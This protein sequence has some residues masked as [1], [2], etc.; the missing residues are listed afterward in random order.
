MKYLRKFIK[1][2]NESSSYDD[3]VNNIREQS[4]LLLS[5]LI[6]RGFEITVSGGIYNESINGVDFRIKLYSP[7]RDFT[8]FKW[9]D[10]KDD[11]LPFLNG[12]DYKPEFISF[13]VD[14]RS[15]T[16]PKIHM[17]AKD[18]LSDRVNLEFSEYRNHMNLIDE[19]NINYIYVRF[20]T[21]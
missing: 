4:S 11:F 16:T 15:Y 10:I 5:Y 19:N 17:S 6:D 12:M 2:F 18:V 9:D 7:S 8:R 13:K 3:I 20:K 14:Y 21:K 1:G